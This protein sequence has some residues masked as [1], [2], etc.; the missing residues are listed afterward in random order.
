MNPAISNVKELTN[1]VCFSRISV[2]LRSIM[3][4][5]NFTVILVQIDHKGLIGMFICFLLFVVDDF[6]SWG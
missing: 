6:I 2:A 1:F 4:G 3:E 5:C